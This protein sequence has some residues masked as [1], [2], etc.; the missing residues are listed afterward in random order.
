MDNKQL[1]RG[2]GREN[3]KS[4]PLLVNGVAVKKGLLV[5][6]IFSMVSYMGICFVFFNLIGRMGK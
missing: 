1:F 5:M 3:E 2:G 4:C 6:Q